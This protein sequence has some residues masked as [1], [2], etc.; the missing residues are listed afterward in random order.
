M[1]AGD[2]VIH[3]LRRRVLLGAS[4]AL[5]APAIIG[6]APKTEPA[7]EGSMTGAGHARGHRLRDGS[8]PAPRETIATPI[9][10]VGGGI[11]GLSAAWW[12]QKAGFKDFVLLELEDAVG[13]NA[14]GARNA[15]S[16][17]PLGAHYIPLPSP[18]ARFVRALMG[19]LGVIEGD[20]FAASP[21]YREE[22]VVNAPQD[23]L[24]MNG[25]WQEGL[26]PRV[27]ASDTDTEQA[28]RFEDMIDAFKRRRSGERKAFALPRSLSAQDADLLALDKL[29][30]ADWLAANNFTS[31]LLR[32]YVD[33]AC[34][35]D[36]GATV[37]QTSAWAALHYFAARDGMGQ[38]IE[39]Q[40]V[41]TWPQ[42]NGWVAE[43][44]AARLKDHIRTGQ[45]V[46]RAQTE[47]RE[48]LVDAWDV[49]ANLT[50][51]YRAARVIWAAH[52]F[53]LARCL[54][55]PHAAL[56]ARVQAAQT[57]PWVVTN[58]T[59]REHPQ[60]TGGAPLAWDNVLFDSASL[61]YVVCTHQT[62][63]RHRAET[64]LTHYLPVTETDTRAARQ[65]LLAQPWQ[66][67]AQH[68]IDDLTGA[69][70][71]L[72]KLVTRA[73]VHVWG[74]AMRRP[75]PGTLWPMPAP[76]NL[77]TPN[78]GALDLAHS[79]ASGLSL[80]EEAN[81]HGVTAAQRALEAIGAQGKA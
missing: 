41:L 23:R 77:G 7:L 67:H 1:A 61:G 8:L 27:S 73:D 57:V 81:F 54:P 64:I 22:Y 58:L 76:L 72:R 9:L 80:F 65:R 6:C 5:A 16:A 2:S 40:S 49:A 13:G 46:F 70:P 20:P 32:W 52:E 36:Y 19:D 62:L 68:A 25:T 45:L 50:R 69:H 42:G 24:Y 66:T 37:T 38:H 71:E 15:V 47:S 35:D 74:H 17:H 33:Y 48:T 63:K 12:L 59:L 14:R 78:L 21:Q 4:A 11:A 53:V 31:P 79:D 56:T 44:L 34:R 75:S 39:P 3:D 29:N 18:E 10:I 28:K 51:R 30:A 26:L 55:Q 60:D 43:Q